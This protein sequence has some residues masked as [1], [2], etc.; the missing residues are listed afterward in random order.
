LLVLNTL[1]QSEIKIYDA[2]QTMHISKCSSI[3]VAEH[4][5]TCIQL[6]GAVPPTSPEFQ[7][8]VDFVIKNY[9]IFKLKELGAAF[10]LYVLGRLD[11]DRNYGSFSPKFFGDVMAEYKKIAVQV[12]NKVE[13]QEEVKQLPMKIDEELAINDELKWWRQSKKDWQM[14]NHQIFDYL[15]KRKL[16]VM[17]KEEGD[18]I[19]EKVKLSLL[20]KALKPK[21]VIITDDQL[22]ILAK[23][24][25]TMIYFNNLKQ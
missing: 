5:K 8:L 20:G 9:G 11:V 18:R 22:K 19:K 10:E 14:I 12:R 4:L 6:S 21:D 7:F 3:E 25:A 17:T 2:L 13:P 1:N 15:W 16:I 23:K 24:Y